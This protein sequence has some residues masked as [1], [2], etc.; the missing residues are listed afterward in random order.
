M[1]QYAL[2]MYK[3]SARVANHQNKGT[4]EDSNENQHS[5]LL[6]NNI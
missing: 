1:N 4:S 2:V 3:P 6:T 5:L